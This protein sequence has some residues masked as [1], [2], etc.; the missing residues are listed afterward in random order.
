MPITKE[1]IDRMK[2]AF[3][4]S[5]RFFFLNMRFAMRENAFINPIA[6]IGMHRKAFRVRVVSIIDVCCQIVDSHFDWSTKTGSYNRERA[7]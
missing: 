5:C 6:I 1:A 2:Q 7:K 4:C 3:I